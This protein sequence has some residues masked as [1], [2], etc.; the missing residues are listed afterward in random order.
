MLVKAGKVEV[1]LQGAPQALFRVT[2]VLGAH[3]QVKFVAMP[4]QQPGGHVRAD[5]A[6]RA[7]QEYCHVAPVVPVPMLS[8]G[9]AVQLGPALPSGLAE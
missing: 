1:Q 6:G 4:F 3:Q 7:R 9:A 5:I 2:R 8:S